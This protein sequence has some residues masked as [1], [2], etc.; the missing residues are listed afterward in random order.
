MILSR[1]QYPRSMVDACIKR[2]LESVFSP[3]PKILSVERK[4]IFLIIPYAGVMSIR[5][6][7]QISRM[8]KLLLYQVKPIVVLKP[9][10]RIG[11]MFPFK[12]K[13]PFALR[14]H[15]VYS[16]QCAS[17]NASYYGQ[18]VRHIHVRACEHIGKSPLTGKTVA[19]PSDSAIYDH[20][21]VCNYIPDARDFKI[22]ATAT[23]DFVLKVKES[24]LIG[25]DKP[26]L[27]RN[28][29]SLPLYLF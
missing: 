22:L 1:N 15:V 25:C 26:A 17:C 20:R 13:I 14:S 21:K 3:R 27:N 5:V 7:D 9:A 2:F 6:R 11:D 10:R 19:N 8:C 4:P 16:F 23:N 24:I 18:T 28:V 29:S 12:D